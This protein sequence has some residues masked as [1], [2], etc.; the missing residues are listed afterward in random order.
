MEKGMSDRSFQG[1][2]ALDE[3]LADD[4][5]ILAIRSAGLTPSQFKAQ[6]G[7]LAVRLD[8]TTR[9]DHRTETRIAA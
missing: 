6:I 7:D 3:L 2:P 8:R 1:E 5:M 4:V 9:R